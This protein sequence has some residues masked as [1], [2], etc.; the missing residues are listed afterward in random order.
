MTA[1]KGKSNIHVTYSEITVPGQV[2]N[3]NALTQAWLTSH[4]GGGERKLGIW[5]CW[6]EPTHGRGRGAASGGP[7]RRRHL[8]DQRQ[9]AGRADGQ[10]RRHDRD[11][12]AARL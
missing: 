3:G 10:G 9:P 11:H 7:Y 5:S 1:V 8:V 4:P 6:D 2:Q 12:L